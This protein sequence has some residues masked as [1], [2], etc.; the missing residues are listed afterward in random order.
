MNLGKSSRLFLYV[1]VCVALIDIFFVGMNYHFSKRSFE[2]NM[3]AES[4]SLYLN[5]QTLLSQTYSNLLTIAT[6]VAS[7]PQVQH[8]F[9]EGHKAVAIE[10]GGAGG[11]EAQKYRTALFDLVG[12]KWRAVQDKFSARQL[13]FHL[14]PGSTSFLRVHKPEK[15]GDNMDD[16]RFT[17]VDTNKMAEPVIGFETGRV[18]SG[19]RGVVPI[20]AVD[21][22]SGERV[23][24][25]ALEVGTSFDVILGI[26]HETSNYSAGVLLTKQH[27]KEAMW[28]EALDR[29]F[30]DQN[31]DCGCVIE[32]SSDDS[33][34]NIIAS[35]RAQGIRFRDGGHEIVK[36]GESSFLVSYFPL[37]DYRGTLLPD[38]DD[39]GAL[40]FWK[41]VDA[42][43]NDLRT[44]QSYNIAYGIIGFIV[45]ELLFFFAFRIG[46]RR[47][48]QV[49][50]KK[51]QQLQISKDRLSEA[52]SIARVGNW[53]WNIT[54]G[55][56][57]WSDQVYK[58]FELDSKQVTPDYNLFLSYIHPDDRDH[59]QAA[60][61]KALST[62][63][64]YAVGHR[65]LLDSG[66][67]IQVLEHGHLECDQSG[68][69]LLMKGTVQDISAQK[70]VEQ[71]LSDV[72]WATG[73]GVWEWDVQKDTLSTNNRWARM[74]GYEIG[75]LQPLCLASWEVLINPEDLSSFREQLHNVLQHKGAI[76]HT[77]VRLRHRDGH[78][79]WIL[80]KGRSLD[81]DEKGR[82]LRLSGSCA[83]ITARKESEMKVLRLATFDTLTGVFNRSV[84][85]EKLAETFALSKRTNQSFALMILD[86]DGFKPINDQYGHPIGDALLKHVASDLKNACRDTDIVARLGGDEFALILP[87]TTDMC[88][89]NCFADRLLEM[90]SRER[91]IE[92]HIIEVH[93]S[94]GCCMYR[95]D[96]LS[97]DEIVKQADSALYKA[98]NSGKNAVRCLC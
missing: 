89:C 95:D 14:G 55:E 38:R 28:P 54:T 92:G 13:H 34:K 5:Y 43:L 24:V 20:T 50:D 59:V 45:I 48:E 64:S 31:T 46:T 44:S 42:P 25:G 27:V 53:E 36:V 67:E 11:V 7:D 82:S 9:N 56:L 91:L 2:Q 51:T 81:R 33:F 37:R 32:A 41:N 10:G 6:F 52:Q 4:E 39:V 12:E 68:K 78:W 57:W 77:E 22:T 69:P 80:I 88:G 86:L 72:I 35:G 84:F 63:G 17:I 73:V 93:A 62:K 40:V 60:V 94:I 49:I 21:S 23:H 71:R 76:I 83:D 66:Q 97:V 29:K 96:F 90:L 3:E 16:V 75:E 98:K 8:L 1:S 19:L 47:L 30:G 58:L 18:Y 65:V 74:V 85:N 15:F 61:N 70:V 87:S 79:V 26:L